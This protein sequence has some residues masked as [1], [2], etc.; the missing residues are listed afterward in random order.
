[1]KYVVDWIFRLLQK[2]PVVAVG[3]LSALTLLTVAAEVFARAGGGGNYS[4]GDSGG[5]GGGGGG[6]GDGEIILWLVYLAFRHPQVGVPLLIVGIIVIV[7][8]NRMN[9]DRTTARAIT[10]LEEMAPPDRSGLAGIV[11]RDP[12]F[13]EARF[14]SW[15]KDIDGRIQQAWSRGDMAPVR[16]HL[17]DGMFRTFSTQ[18]AIM[19]H[20]GRRNAVADHRILQCRIHAVEQN[21]RFDTIHVAIE[22]S[23]RD[24]EVEAS[25][26]F[27]EAMARAMKKSPSTYTEIWSFLRRPGATTLDPERAVSGACPSCG[28]PAQNVQAQKCAY[29]GALVNSGDYDWVLAE[30]TQT[31]E[32]RSASKGRVPGLDE[33]TQSDPFFARQVAEDRATYVFWRWLEAQATGSKSA[34]AT[35]AMPG[36]REQATVPGGSG[37][38]LAAVGAVDLVQCEAGDPAGGR[39]DLFFAKVLWSSAPSASAAP[40]QRSVV[41]KLHRDGRPSTDSGLSHAHCPECHGPLPENDA[42]TCAYCGAALGAGKGEWVLEEVMSPY[43][44]TAAAR[45]AEAVTLPGDGQ[46]AEIPAWAMPDLGSK[47]ERTILLM[48][49]AAIVA[50]D[51]Q[52]TKEERRLLK[53]AAKRWGLDVALVEP[54][55]QGQV[56]AALVEELRPQNPWAFLD[57]LIGAALIDGRIDGREQKLLLDVAQN[58]GIDAAQ[59]K[60]RMGELARKAKVN[61]VG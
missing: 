18:L 52:V 10:R 48:R 33:L 24:A 3:A 61:Q 5:G 37:H 40:V 55:L 45:R 2:V 28:A 7:A 11:Q 26:S 39:P 22:A 6:D 53:T 49:M 20:Q 8:K 32:W 59:A 19:A 50:A 42:A 27:D 4:G 35:C 58:A 23:S 34:L 57:G 47:Q 9:P 16:N 15:V 1:M 51:N 14:L 41:L 21:A 44:M 36:L 60:N 29:C 43:D 30:I 46:A 12:G 56:D 25:L 17:S 31:M 54:I 13:D 38:Y